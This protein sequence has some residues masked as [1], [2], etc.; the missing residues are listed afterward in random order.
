MAQDPFRPAAG[1]LSSFVPQ[2]TTRLRLQRDNFMEISAAVSKI[3]SNNL[4]EDYREA[5]DEGA[6]LWTG[7]QQFFEDAAK[8]IEGQNMDPG[9][10]RLAYARL[11]EKLI[12][13]G[14]VG[15]EMT[16]AHIVGFSAARARTLVS[17]VQRKA[18]TTIPEV[19]QTTDEDE[20]PMPAG[21]Q[22]AFNEVVGELRQSLAPSTTAQNVFNEGVA[23]AQAEYL[24]NAQAARGDLLVSHQRRMRAQEMSHGNG[25]ELPGALAVLG[26]TMVFPTEGFDGSE[27]FRVLSAV[28]TQHIRNAMGAQVEDAPGL[29]VDTL[30]AE[31]TTLASNKDSVGAETLLMFAQLVDN[32]RGIA[33][34]ADSS[35]G[36]RST[37]VKLA[38]ALEYVRKRKEDDEAT[39]IPDNLNRQKNLWS[40]HGEARLLVG[41]A[42]Y[43][44]HPTASPSDAGDME[45]GF[46]LSNEIL[47]Q[48]AE[49]L[50]V[51]VADL[52]EDLVE[53]VED[54]LRF[55]ILKSKE[56]R[57][58]DERDMRHHQDQLLEM[59]AE[60]GREYLQQQVQ[61]TPTALTSLHSILDYKDLRSREKDA[62]FGDRP[63]P[64]V[65]LQRGY[66]SVLNP[67]VHAGLVEK[68]YT[69][70]SG[71][72][73][74]LDAV[75]ENTR[76]QDF[77][78][79]VLEYLESPKVAASL[80]ALDA[81]ISA[82]R[83]EPGEIM[84]EQGRLAGLQ[85]M[86]GLEALSSRA[87]RGLSPEDYRTFENSRYALA[88][89]VADRRNPPIDRLTERLVGQLRSE[90]QAKYPDAAG[91]PGFT[92][93]L[94][95]AVTGFLSEVDFW[96]QE[97]GHRVSREDFSKNYFKDVHDIFLKTVDPIRDT[98]DS[99]AAGVVGEGDLAVLEQI[100]PLQDLQDRFKFVQQN[101]EYE[102][103]PEFD[104]AILKDPED[105]V[106]G[107]K[108]R[109]GDIDLNE[110]NQRTLQILHSYPEETRGAV[111]VE[112]LSQ[113]GVTPEEI[114]A[115]VA[116]RA[117]TVRFQKVGFLTDDEVY[118]GYWPNRVHS[119]LGF[120]KDQP[121]QSTTR[122]ESSNWFYRAYEVTTEV[123]LDFE[124]QK[125]DPL[126]TRVFSSKSLRKWEKDPVSLKIILGRLRF[127]TDTEEIYQESLRSLREFV[128]HQEQTKLRVKED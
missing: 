103:A 72:L 90:M 43:T 13:G 14:L 4:Q 21:A 3:V 41:L 48:Y 77:R 10:K 92:A 49:E 56:A 35:G 58:P 39:E 28:A 1:P 33:L 98:L 62:L 12:E 117:T 38:S 75:L 126:T 66:E 119:S 51:P 105:L 23:R 27:G 104:R 109:Q 53:N 6:G 79:A 67:S 20:D 70:R 89:R 78:A 8:K 29:Y 42:E 36:S 22:A 84:L 50:G 99:L 85:D 108:L 87:Q 102:R 123:P 100:E 88:L 95:G 47:G 55:R 111:A 60:E 112:L 73:E 61:L 114:L 128:V 118:E 101:V 15:R 44:A 5:E 68:A 122:V 107:E 120:A 83:E 71:I 115:G 26:T 76:P 96:K 37:Q 57:E 30:I 45:L 93:A 2:R 34:G 124:A 82:A 59:T 110:F 64:T 31:A 16:P 94:G 127:P 125:L 19:A 97:E 52:P 121:P 24:G 69:A 116:T 106:L 17:E 74:G 63:L 32:G 40:L 46:Q 25:E 81:E 18:A 65:L 113:Q 54:T 9:E 7:Q 80:D 91:T 86:S 11:S